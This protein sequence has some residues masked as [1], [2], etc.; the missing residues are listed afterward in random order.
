[1][2][3]PKSA[4]AIAT[5]MRLGVVNLKSRR[6]ATTST[7]QLF[8]VIPFSSKRNETQQMCK[9]LEETVQRQKAR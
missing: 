5:F 2:S 9:Q 4:P 6:D 1:M 7:G 8:T 3:V